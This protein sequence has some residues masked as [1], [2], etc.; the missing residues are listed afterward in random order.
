MKRCVSQTK[1]MTLASL[2]MSPLGWISRDGK[3]AFTS[4]CPAIC[5]AVVSHDLV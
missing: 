5:R 2:E 3:Q 4:W 1:S